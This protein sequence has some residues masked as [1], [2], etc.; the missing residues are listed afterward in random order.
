VVTVS[1][2]PSKKRTRPCAFCGKFFARVERHITSFHRKEQKVQDI[3]QLPWKQ[4]K[5]AMKLMKREGLLKHNKVQLGL[6]VPVLE[7]ERKQTEGGK[8]KLVLCSCCSGLF[9]NQYF[10]KHRV[11]CKPLGTDQPSEKP[12]RIQI[13]LLKDSSLRQ[14]F[15]ENILSKLR[16]DDIG[17]LCKSDDII[18]MV[19]SRLFDKLRKKPDKLAEVSRSVRTD[20]R[21]LARLFLAFQTIKGAAGT[22]VSHAAVQQPASPN[23]PAQPVK[24]LASDMLARRSLPMLEQAIVACTEEETDTSLKAGLKIGL[25]Y[26]V[27][28]L[29]KIVKASYLMQEEDDKAADVAKFIEVYYFESILDT[30]YLLLYHCHAHILTSQCSAH[31][32]SLFNYLALCSFQHL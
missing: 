3:L 16:D 21:R 9:S 27:K 30:R 17:T 19:G 2:H 32:C 10:R 15:R 18:V 14:D 11:H 24:G 4:Q 28:K 23:Q 20:M 25:L 7:R 31:L 26:L 13:D 1:N 22:S 12:T 29:A 5:V 6:A 8:T